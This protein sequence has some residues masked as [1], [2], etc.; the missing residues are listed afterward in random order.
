MRF[1]H[2]TFVALPAFLLLLCTPFPVVADNGLVLIKGTEGATVKVDGK[3]AGILPLGEIHLPEGAHSI[4]AFKQGYQ[5]ART[6][7]HL[8]SLRGETVVLYLKPKSAD[9]AALRNLAFPG[10]GSW[11][12]ERRRDAL[13]YLATQSILV[14]YALFENSRFE[15]YRDDYETALE[16][17]ENALSAHEIA[18]TKAVR[19]DAYNNL[20]SSESNRN[21]ALWATLIVQLLSAADGWLRFPFE[22]A[23]EDRIALISENSSPAG[24]CSSLALR[25][26][27]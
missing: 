4:N 16:E 20:S 15:S 27:F 2:F 9:G 19:D 25:L 13:G 3:V 21:A 12:S 18:S 23:G 11:Y 22:E 7:V 5:S 14:G 17:Y 26:R 1:F 24:N 8:L 6:D 10:W